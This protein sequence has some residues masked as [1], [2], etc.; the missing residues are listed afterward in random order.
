MIQIREFRDADAAMASVVYFESF[1]TFLGERMETDAPRPAEFWRKSMRHTR[2][3]D[4]ESVSFVA[5]EEGRIIGCITVDASLKRGLGSLVRIGVL[6]GSGGKGVGRML[7]LAADRFWRERKMRK[8]ATC[9][10]SINPGAL[11]FYQSCGFHVEGTLKDHFFK[12]VD[13]NQL[14]LFY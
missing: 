6:P 10:S 4:Y 1:K 12:G 7:F 3:D 13:E 8:V 9:V 14:A 5:E 11:R 2:T